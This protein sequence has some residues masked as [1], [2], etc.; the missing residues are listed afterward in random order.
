MDDLYL[1]TDGYQFNDEF[2][3]LSIT[4]Q[5]DDEEISHLLRQNGKIEAHIL[6]A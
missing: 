4:D 6:E 2:E 5:D 3:D 1:Y